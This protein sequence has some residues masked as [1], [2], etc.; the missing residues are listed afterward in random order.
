[1]AA[2]FPVMAVLGTPPT[3]TVGWGTIDLDADV[4]TVKAPNGRQ[5]TTHIG[6]MPVDVLAR[7]LLAE[8]LRPLWEGP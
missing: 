4:I 8:C 2:W 1:M 5:E 7:Q 6:R 3:F